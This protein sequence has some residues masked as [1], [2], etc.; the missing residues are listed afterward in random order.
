[1]ILNSQRNSDRNPSKWHKAEQGPERVE[2]TP[3]NATIAR[4]ERIASTGVTPLDVMIADMRLHYDLYQQALAHR[5]DIATAKTELKE[6]RDAA[7][8]AAPYTHP[9]LAAVEH[10]GK[11]SGPIEISD[12][13]E[14]LAHILLGKLTADRI[15]GS[16]PWR[17]WVY[18]TT[19]SNSFPFIS[20]SALLSFKDDLCQRPLICEEP[21]EKSC[22]NGYQRLPILEI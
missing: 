9:G 10:M 2:N 17:S 5:E 11:G 3:N 14:C 18:L 13:K 21:A 20:F 8:D 4:Q 22:T 19:D 1:M 12:A 16:Q 7:K 6:A 15:R